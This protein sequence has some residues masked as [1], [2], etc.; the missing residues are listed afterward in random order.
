MRIHERIRERQ[1][2]GAEYPGHA[3]TH[4]VIPGALPGLNE[5]ISACRRNRYAGAQQKK[6]VESSI[7]AAIQSQCPGVSY[8]C[9][10]YL[11]ITWVCADRRRD[12]D[13]IAAGKKFLLD[14]MVKAGLIRGDGWRDV[15][16]FDDRFELGDPRVIVS[17]T[18]FTDP[19]ELKLRFFC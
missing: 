11:R 6:R 1:T 19:Q 4:L 18:P 14:A 13:N 8:S 10:V 5:I 16:G 7:M 15:V 9:P 3:P 12:R 2:R 17:I